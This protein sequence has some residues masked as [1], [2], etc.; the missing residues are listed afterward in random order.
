MFPFNATTAICL[1]PVQMANMSP[2]LGGHYYHLLPTPTLPALNGTT[3][4]SYCRSH[5]W[6][7]SGAFSNDAYTW[8]SSHYI[9]DGLYASIEQCCQYRLDPFPLFG[10]IGGEYAALP[11][12]LARSS[13]GW[14][15]GH[16]VAFWVRLCDCLGSLSPLPH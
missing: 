13:C 5:W 9:P 6:N 14:V 16:D 12:Q 15:R 4:S 8:V 1:Y 3:A 2:I 10:G 11:F 7:R